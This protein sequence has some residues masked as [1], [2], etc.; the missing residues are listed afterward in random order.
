[1]VQDEFLGP[2]DFLAVDFPNGRVTSEGFACLMDLVSR[3]VIRV[4][5]LEFVAK[6]S[7]GIAR[8]VP[9]QS[10]DHEAA[11][12][13]AAWQ[14]AESHLLDQSDLD[15]IGAELAPGS[16]A[17][18]VVYENVWATPLI[19][20]LEHSGARIMGHGRVA[21]DDLMTSLG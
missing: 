6:S 7:A 16:V 13:V 20:A 17:G 4:L 3:D 19:A 2:I 15:A 9:L 11:V 21:D 12:D 18:V 1:L 14:A 10:L 8:S 5:D